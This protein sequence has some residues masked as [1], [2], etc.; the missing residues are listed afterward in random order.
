[1]VRSPVRYATWGENRGR[2]LWTGTAGDSCVG[3]QSEK[4][5]KVVDIGSLFRYNY[6]RAT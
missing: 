3:A 1:M 6:Y 4:I 2:K 5:K